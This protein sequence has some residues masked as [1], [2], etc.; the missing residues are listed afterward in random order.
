MQSTTYERISPDYLSSMQALTA[1]A[2]DSG[3]IWRRHGIGCLQAYVAEGPVETRIHI[4]S[5]ELMLQGIDLS[6]NAHNHRF[7]LSSTVLFGSLRHTEWHLYPR[8]GGEYETYDFVH[9]RLHTDDNRADMRP[10]GECFTVAKEG[11]VFDI[12]DSYTF[13][14]GAFHDSCPVTP[15][16]V[17]LVTKTQQTDMRAQ[18]VAPFGIPPVPAFSGEPLSDIVVKPLLERAVRA[19]VRASTSDRTAVRHG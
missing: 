3:L 6:G 9:A 16:V 11:T 2:I 7:E 15:L 4:W 1:R 18:V 12:G 17:T 14:R 10:T 8:N 5:P 13:E 19:L